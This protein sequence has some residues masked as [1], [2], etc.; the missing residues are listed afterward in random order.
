MRNPLY[1]KQLNQLVH[2]FVE[3]DSAVE[4]IE[5]ADGS[6]EHWQLQELSERLQV[7]L[8]LVDTLPLPN[9][10]KRA[11]RDVGDFFYLLNTLVSEALEQSKAE[12]LPTVREARK[13]DSDLFETSTFF[14]LESLE[15]VYVY[16][17]KA[18]A[19]LRKPAN[20]YGLS[21]EKIFVPHD[22]EPKDPTE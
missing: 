8:P 12:L 3:I 11:G 17:A 13:Y 21:C 10:A 15:K 7:L 19:T 16:R 18:R 20:D 4:R 14:E 22:P 5:R 2:S 6:L 1:V 9:S